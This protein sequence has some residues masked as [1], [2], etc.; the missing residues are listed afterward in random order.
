MA[1]SRKKKHNLLKLLY[2]KHWKFL[3]KLSAESASGTAAASKPASSS[4]LSSVAR[5]VAGFMISN[6]VL[7]GV[8]SGVMDLL[9]KNKDLPVTRVVD[10]LMSNKDTPETEKYLYFDPKM[11]KVKG[12]VQR[13]GRSSAPF[14]DAFV[15]V[16]GGGNFSEFHALQEYAKR[17]SSA[18][19][20]KNIVYGSTEIVAPR[21][22]AAQLAALGAAVSPEAGA[23]KKHTEAVGVTD[24][25]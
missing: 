25:L 17:S 11:F 1:S 4:G 16:L 23:D 22:F 12:A 5:S 9:P 19:S 15:F 3:N 24:A 13:T 21:Q 8:F 6:K 20:V 10:A 2:L 18:A 14:R 7:S